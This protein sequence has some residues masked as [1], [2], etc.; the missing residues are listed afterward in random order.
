MFERFPEPGRSQ[1]AAARDEGRTR[2][3]WCFAE[4]QARLAYWAPFPG[5]PPAVVWQFDPGPDPV[6]AAGL[7]RRSRAAMGLDKIICDIPLQ[8][9][10]T[11][12]VDRA[13]EHEALTLAGFEM[14]VER[15]AL[16]WTAGTDLPPDP[17]RLTYRPA[18]RLPAA[19]VI[20]LLVRISRGSLDHDTR[21]EVARSGEAAEA[22]WMYDDLTARKGKPGWFVI[23]YLGDSPVGLVAPDDYS[24][25]YIGVVPEHRGRRYVDDLLARGTRTL[26]EAGLPRVAA[27]TD[28][29]NV[30]S[31]N[32]FL[33]AG[34]SVV[35]RV[36]RYYWRKT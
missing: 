13:V 7:L 25:A 24:I 4:G 35:G 29:G 30:P 3:E 8:P 17:G 31:A 1:L 36:F 27:A 22:R 15:L 18:R 20:D 11:P 14:A 34:Y 26:A 33:R 23:G 2:P 10:L 9:G 6:A 5:A 32:A 28:A 16:E 12:D 21:V 19:E